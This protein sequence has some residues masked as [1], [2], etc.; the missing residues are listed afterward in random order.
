MHNP[1]PLMRDSYVGD[2]KRYYK[3]AGINQSPVT[4]IQVGGLILL[5]EVT[6]LLHSSYKIN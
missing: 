4:L 1:K 3:L 6:E 2:I 5:S